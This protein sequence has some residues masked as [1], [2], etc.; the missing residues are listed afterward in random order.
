MTA[1]LS[2][3]SDSTPHEHGASPSHDEGAWCSYGLPHGCGQFL[4]LSHFTRGYAPPYY[5][6]ARGLIPT[7][8]NEQAPWSDGMR[9]EIYRAM[10]KV[11]SE[12]RVWNRIRELV[13]E[14]AVTASVD[15]PNL[16]G[17]VLCWCVTRGPFA[18][19]PHD[20][21]C[22]EL[23]ALLSTTQSASAS[24]REASGERNDD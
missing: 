12:R 4:P 20:D 8:A 2:T 5:T 23:R 18:R 10:S 1:R 7:R 3:S 15:D 22:V 19:G 14:M 6:D 24:V 9:Q 21:R 16:E 17:D 11:F 13:Q